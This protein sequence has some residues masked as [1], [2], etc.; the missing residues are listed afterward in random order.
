M[1][2]FFWLFNNGT[3]KAQSFILT[4]DLKSTTQIFITYTASSSRPQQFV[5]LVLEFMVQWPHFLQDL[6]RTIKGKL[7]LKA[8]G[9]AN[10]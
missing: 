8:V 1:L 2:C 6:P 7:R 9:Q 10:G 5:N 3:Y 4:D